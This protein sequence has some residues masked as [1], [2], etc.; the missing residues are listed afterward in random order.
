MAEEIENGTF[1]F[2]IGFGS[3]LFFYMLILKPM[4]LR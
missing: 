1:Q 3:G 4:F 2:F